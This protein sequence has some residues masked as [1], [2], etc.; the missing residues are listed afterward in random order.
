MLPRALGLTLLV[1]AMAACERQQTPAKAT[2]PRPHFLADVPIMPTSIVTD[3]TGAVDA[4]HRGLAVQ[5]PMD[6]VAAYYRRELAARGWRL[7]SDVSDT[8]RVTLFLQ[9]PDRSLW[10]QIHRLGP[11]ACEYALTAAAAT[12]QGASR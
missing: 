11:L 10:V 4:E 1:L 2:P 9:R 5:R 6:S 8:A 7:L 3:T 12:P